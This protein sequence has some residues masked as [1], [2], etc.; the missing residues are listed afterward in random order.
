MTEIFSIRPILV[1][2]SRQDYQESHASHDI[3]S[4]STLIR[5]I[6]EQHCCAIQPL[7][8]ESKC[9]RDKQ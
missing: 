1:R 5:V 6:D 2:N 9:E 3:N 8:K 7:K 4:R